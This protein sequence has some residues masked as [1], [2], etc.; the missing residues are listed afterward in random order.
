MKG[1]EP[2]VGHGPWSC[3]VYTTPKACRDRLDD[4]GR[5]TACANTVHKDDCPPRYKCPNHNDANHHRW[6]C[7]PKGHPGKQEPGSS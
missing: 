1:K 4:L 3:P 6:T 5:C 2:I 7:D